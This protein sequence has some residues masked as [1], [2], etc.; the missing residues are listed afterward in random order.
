MTLS[1]PGRAKDVTYI[2]VLRYI[3][4]N[5]FLVFLFQMIIIIAEN[6]IEELN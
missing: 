4:L 2:L 6:V 3:Y 5:T 1:S